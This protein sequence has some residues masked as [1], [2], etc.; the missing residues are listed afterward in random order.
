MNHG[1]SSG[2]AGGG[3][4]TLR[5]STSFADHH[6]RQPD[7]QRLS[8]HSNVSIEDLRHSIHSTN[9]SV[10]SNLSI[11]DLTDRSTHE[12]QQQRALLNNNKQTSFLSTATGHYSFVSTVKGDR[13]QSAVPKFSAHKN[14]PL[15]GSK[16]SVKL[17]RDLMELLSSKKVLDPLAVEPGSDISVSDVASLSDLDAFAADLKDTPN[18]EEPMEDVMQGISNILEDLDCNDDETTSMNVSLPGMMVS[19]TPNDMQAQLS[20]AEAH[21]SGRIVE[22]FGPSPTKAPRPNQDKNELDDSIETFGSNN[23]TG[24]DSSEPSASFAEESSGEYAPIRMSDRSYRSAF[25]SRRG[26]FASTGS[27]LESISE[28]AV[29]EEELGNVPG[30]SEFMFGSVSSVNTSDLEVL[31]NIVSLDQVNHRSSFTLGSSLGSDKGDVNDSITDDESQLNEALINILQHDGASQNDIS[32]DN[33]DDEDLEFYA[34]V[35]A[36]SMD[37]Q[38]SG[39]DKVVTLKKPS[40]VG[41]D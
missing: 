19:R 2:G 10:H 1:F 28:V 4:G 37:E 32:E 11:G 3:K 38:E 17:S 31:R 5:H 22:A 14:A 30:S 25:S 13:V 41:R 36:D 35:F 18:P 15:K 27:A 16:Q 8:V 34:Q 33:I 26:S 29:F 20:M 39:I 21:D 23:N 24:D 40:T 7:H 6:H 9:L 12:Q